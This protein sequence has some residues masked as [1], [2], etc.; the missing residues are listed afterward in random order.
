MLQEGKDMS[1]ETDDAVASVTARSADLVEEYTDKL[2][3][4]VNGLVPPFLGRRE[5]REVPLA[6][7][8]CEGASTGSKAS[9]A[10]GRGSAT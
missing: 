7:P 8:S 10:R 9:T 2:N 6:A 3:A 4:F 1:T 5:E